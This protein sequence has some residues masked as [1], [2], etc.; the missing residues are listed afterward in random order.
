VFEPSAFRKILYLGGKKAAAEHRP[1][2]ERVL[3][4][5]P[6]AKLGVLLGLPNAL[7]MLVAA[8]FSILIGDSTFAVVWAIGAAVMLVGGVALPGMTRRRAS[9][10]AGKNDILF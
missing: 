2:L 10:I 1:W 8:A 7:I 6:P 5:T 3:G 9:R 4:T